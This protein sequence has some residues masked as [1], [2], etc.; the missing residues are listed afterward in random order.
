MTERLD[1]KSYEPREGSCGIEVAHP[2]LNV[3]EFL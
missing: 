3:L 1:G 2:H